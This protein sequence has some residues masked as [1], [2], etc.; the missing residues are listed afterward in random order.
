MSRL[1]SQLENI[2]H[3]RTDGETPGPDQEAASAAVPPAST[4]AG[5]QGL[6]AASPPLTEAPAKPNYG[7][8]SALQLQIPGYAIASQ[9]AL[10]SRPQ[11][12]A[13]PSR[14][15]WP[16]R[17]WFLFLLALIGISLAMLLTPR[18]DNASVKGPVPGPA[19]MAVTPKADDEPLQPP[20]LPSPARKA[21]AAI[22]KKPGPAATP[23]AR[24]AD[25]PIARRQPPRS[26]QPSQPSQAPA[27]QPAAA[28]R[29]PAGDAACSAAMAAM[30]LCSAPHP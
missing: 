8:A 10:S 6:S 16:V 28:P 26:S 23:I 19:S 4:Q 1:F 29:T 24:P 27:D 14:A 15:T 12:P 18:D 11:P 20:D 13:M 25:P 7:P 5:P 17:L 9:L 22:E 21:Q 3:G 2:G 30:N